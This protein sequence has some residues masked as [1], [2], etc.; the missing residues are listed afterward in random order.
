MRRH[1]A[2][3]P[4]ISRRTLDG[5]SAEQHWRS[6]SNVCSSVNPA[7]AAARMERLVIQNNVPMCRPL[8]SAKRLN[9]ASARGAGAKNTTSKLG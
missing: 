7:A 2:N 4:E 5:S 3:H 6:V 9:S 8:R 1:C